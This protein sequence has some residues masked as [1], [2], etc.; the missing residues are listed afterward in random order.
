MFIDATLNVGLNRNTGGTVGLVVAIIKIG[1]YFKILDIKTAYSPTEKTL[2]CR[3]SGP[4][5]SLASDVY[6]LANELSQDF[7]AMSLDGG[8]TG[9]LIGPKASKWGDFNPEYFISF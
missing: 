8:K 5:D 2:I 7:I 3:V 9:K 1:E 4:W 6:N